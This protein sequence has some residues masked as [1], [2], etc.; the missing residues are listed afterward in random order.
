MIFKVLKEFQAKT[1][2]ET[3]TLKKGQKIKLSGDEAIPLIQNGKIT[4]IERVMYKVYSELL[5]GYLWIVDTDKDMHS[6]RSQGV[7]EAIYTEDEIRKLKGIS[8]SSLKEIYKFKEVFEKSKVEEI[9]K[10]T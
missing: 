6:L 7:S 5:G 2:T 4:P 8:K 10:E 1:L 9:K 3:L